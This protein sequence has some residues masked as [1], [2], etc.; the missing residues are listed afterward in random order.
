[1]AIGPLERDVLR[2]R[3][4]EQYKD[5]SAV[6]ATVGLDLALR[7]FE[8]SRKRLDKGALDWDQYVPL[9]GHYNA[10]ASGVLDALN[11]KGLTP[12]VVQTWKKTHARYW[13]ELEEPSYMTEYCKDLFQKL[14]P[15]IVSTHS[16]LKALNNMLVSLRE[17]GSDPKSAAIIRSSIEA[18]TAGMNKAGF[19]IEVR[20]LRGIYG[21]DTTTDFLWMEKYVPRLTNPHLTPAAPNAAPAS[22]LFPQP[23]RPKGLQKCKPSGDFD[24]DPTLSPEPVGEEWEEVLGTPPGA[25]APSKPASS[26]I[27]AETP[28]RPRGLQKSSSSADPF[29]IDTDSFGM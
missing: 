16:S 29:D 14:I 4:Y 19:G 26:S 11:G 1:M 8:L 10:T 21:M 25:V 18:N 23:A 3:V 22:A 9:R 12:K 6:A 20:A 5:Q 2:K 7:G 24:G 28:K 15:H 27:A 13:T 17:K